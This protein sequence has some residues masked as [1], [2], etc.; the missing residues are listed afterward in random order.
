MFH[1]IIF[2][3]FGVPK[4][5]IS[6]GG[7]HFTDGN[8]RKYLKTQGVEH[9]VATPYNPQTS[10]QVETSNKQIK[11]ILQKTVHE[12]GRGWKE[13]SRSIVG[14][15]YDIQNSHRYDTLSIGL[16]EDMPFTRRIGVQITLGYQEVAYG[17][18]HRQNQKTNAIGLTRGMEG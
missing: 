5:V 8:L 13:T 11:N 1:D 6:D 3:R 4:V 9:R 15:W 12:M 17:S 10:C 7:S 16:W 2:P 14:I 18:S